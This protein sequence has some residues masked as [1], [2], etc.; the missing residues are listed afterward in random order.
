LIISAITAAIALCAL[1]PGGRTEA[2]EP[3]LPDLGG[4]YQCQPNPTPCLWAG[5]TPSIS[6]S[7]SKLDIKNDKG[8]PATATL[9]SAMTISAGGPFNSYGV[10][11]PDHSID[12]SN[13]TTWRKQ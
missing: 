8:E 13:G 6:Q 9:T 7:G 10:I 3:S 1:A 4:T 5:Q 2:Q 11:R 12:W